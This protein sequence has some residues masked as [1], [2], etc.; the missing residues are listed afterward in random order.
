MKLENLIEC[1][2]TREE[3]AYTLQSIE[4]LGVVVIEIVRYLCR[5]SQVTT[6]LIADSPS[7]HFQT[8]TQRR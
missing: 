5:I 8:T 2:I 3:V 4:N 1:R 6:T 7:K